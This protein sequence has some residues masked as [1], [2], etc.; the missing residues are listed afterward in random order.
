MMQRF[1]G[2]DV[3][4]TRHQPL[5]KQRDL[6]RHA[7]AL[8]GACAI[9]ATRRPSMRMFALAA[10]LVVLGIEGVT[11]AS[12]PRQRRWNVWGH[13]PKYIQVI[14]EQGTGGRVQPMP[15]YP[16]NT[17]SVFGHS[18]LDSLTLVTSPRIFELYRR[19]FHARVGHL[20]GRDG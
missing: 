14:T 9:L 15:L 6:E 7:P 18:T 10:M 2:V 11:N 8:A 5:I 12:F 13:P 20:Q 4:Q 19:Y 3:A 16:A 1:N 17:P